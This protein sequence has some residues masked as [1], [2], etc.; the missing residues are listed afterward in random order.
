MSCN[1]CSLNFSHIQ[2]FTSTQTF[3]GMVDCNTA[4]FS[5]NQYCLQTPSLWIQSCNMAA[6]DF[7]PA[8][9]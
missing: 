7:N 2:T 9:I 8:M 1:T 5:Q 3:N 4:C 6:N